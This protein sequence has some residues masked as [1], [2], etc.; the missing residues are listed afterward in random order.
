MAVT[1]DE[2]TLMSTSGTDLDL[3]DN[4]MSKSTQQDSSTPL[5]PLPSTSPSSPLSLPFRLYALGSNSSFQ[6]GLPHNRDVWAPEQCLFHNIDSS[7]PVKAELLASAADIKQ[8]RSFR[9]LVAG[10]NH[11]L[12]L[13]ESGEVYAAGENGDGWCGLFDSSQHGVSNRGFRRVV[14]RDRR[15]RSEEVGDDGENVGTTSEIRFVDVAA[16]WSASFLLDEQERIWVCGSGEKGELGLGEEVRKCRLGGHVLHLPDHDE[17][18][19]DSGSKKAFIR[20]GMGHVIFFASNGVVYGWGTRRKGQLGP[21]AVSSRLSWRPRRLRVPFQDIVD[22]HIGRTFTLFVGKNSQTCLWGTQDGLPASIP[23]VR[24]TVPTQSGAGWSHIF[25]L[26]DGRLTGFG[27]GNKGQVP[28]DKLSHVKTFAAGSE[29]CVAITAQDEVITWGW[30][31]H[32][33][34]GLP[35]D[36]R[37]NVVGRW[38]VIS[39]SLRERENFVAV[40]AGCATTFVVV[41]QT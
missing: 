41:E 29:H 18:M 8:R 37:G 6:L 36:A 9:K 7:S 27:P 32:G 10:G 3:D 34:C 1:N 12:V 15:L 31:E 22:V 39:L 25:T 11:T 20:A 13:L 40:A 24:S 14:L 23:V 19:S 2:S 5:N 38:N 28:S 17:N 4:T 21:E 26:A 30:G 16:T 33:N 35:V